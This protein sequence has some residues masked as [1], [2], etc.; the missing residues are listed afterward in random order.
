MTSSSRRDPRRDTRRT[1]RRTTRRKKRNPLWKTLLIV[2]WFILALFC[3]G[4]IAV[5]H[6]QDKI[7]R[8]RYEELQERMKEQ[9]KKQEEEN[10]RIKAEKEAQEA[11]E[12]AKKEAEEK[13]KEEQEEAERLAQEEA[14]RLA[15]EEAA[16][17]PVI[18]PQYESFYADNS[19]TYGWIRIDDTVIDYPV[20]HTPD[21]P[22]YYEHLTFEK[23]ESKYGSIFIDYRTT[24]DT[25][26]TLVFGH[27]MKDR[28]MFGSLRE[29]KNK[30]Y[31]N[32]HQYIHFNTLY[33]EGLYQIVAVAKGVVYYDKNAIPKDAYLFYDHIELDTEEEF[34]EYMDYMKNNSWIDTGLTAEYGDKLITLVTCDY[35]TTNARLL[36]VAKKVDSIQE[37]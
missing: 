15:A 14:E 9:A 31:Y 36:I 3:I 28:T 13:L 20:M 35:W 33:E 8:Q 10:K 17:Q 2:A 34:N 30:K 19:D 5:N 32:N 12:R 24:E 7:E 27:N 22:N 11:E 6:Y 26:N 29:Y 1:T 37:D 21:R 23:V 18:M 25:E 16:K 4:N